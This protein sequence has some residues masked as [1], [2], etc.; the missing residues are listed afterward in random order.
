MLCLTYVSVGNHKVDATFMVELHFA[1]TVEPLS[2]LEITVCRQTLSDQILKTNSQFHIMIGQ[3]DQTS[4]Q[5]ILTYLL[6]GPIFKMSN[7]K[8]DLKDI[9]CPVNNKI[10]PST[11]LSNSTEII[12][13]K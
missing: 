8:K 1:Y 11:V 4:H 6:Q 5:H 13:T 3:D 12:S 7:Q 2:M 9:I 10:F